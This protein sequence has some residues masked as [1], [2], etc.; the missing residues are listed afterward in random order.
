MF[1]P[2]KRRKKEPSVVVASCVFN[3][4]KEKCPMWVVLYS[5]VK[6]KDGKI[7]KDLKTEKCAFAWIPTLLVEIKEKM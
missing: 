6:D 5:K 1:N 3:C 7:L 2:F 4:S